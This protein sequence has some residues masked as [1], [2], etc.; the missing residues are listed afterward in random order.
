MN[1]FKNPNAFYDDFG[2]SPPEGYSESNGSIAV[3]GVGQVTLQSGDSP[4]PSAGDVLRMK[5]T[6]RGT[7]PVAVYPSQSSAPMPWDDYFELEAGQSLVYEHD[8]VGSYPIRLNF[9][10]RTGN[11]YAIDVLLEDPEGGNG[12]QQP[13]PVEGADTYSLKGFFSFGALTDNDERAV[14]PLGEL[15]VRSQTF[16]R[17]RELFTTGVAGS[18]STAIT[19][20]I[21]SSRSTADGPV[22]TPLTIGDMLASMGAWMWNEAGNGSFTSNPEIFRQALLAEYGTRIYDLNVG[23]MIQQGTIWLPESVT[24]YVFEEQPQTMQA[25]VADGRV[26]PS[27]GYLSKARVKMWLANAAFATQYDEYSFEF[28]APVDTLD[29]FFKTRGQVEELVAKRTDEE[30]FLKLQ[31]LADGDPYTLAK[32]IMFEFRDPTD[33]TYRLPTNWR[34]LIWGAAGDNIDAIKERLI[35]WILDNSE[36]TREEWAEIFPDI[37]TSTEF[38]LIPVYNPMAIPNKTLEPGMY[39]PVVE[40]ARA[41]PLA[42]KFSIGTAYTDAHVDRVNTVVPTSYKTLSLLAVGGPQNRDGVNKFFDQWT[43]YLAIATSNLDFDRMDPVTQGFIGKLHMLMKIAEEMT[44]FS[45]I[46]AGFTRLKRQ[47]TDGTVVMYVVA[48][49]ENV[50]YL[51]VS[52]YSFNRL[53]PPVTS[54]PLR[55]TVQGVEGVTT[56]ENGEPEQEYQEL[57]RA[58]GGTAPYTYS[59]PDAP[60]AYIEAQSI[61]PV[62]GIYRATFRRGGQIKLR[63]SATDATGAVAT[64]EFDLYVRELV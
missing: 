48:S 20:T 21:F 12:G 32:S 49:Y 6:N 62:T 52:K 16:S 15:S 42:R 4:M 24:F 26:D 7:G 63:V 47:K 34:F 17:D 38:I 18:N 45:D 27:P 5:V 64:T 35:E 8:L 1:F 59:L 11:V 31:Q 14:A 33:P 46:P 13:D 51:V 39:S 30:V 54:S 41:N 23:T 9:S 56:L 22:D 10:V 50:Q 60:H 55:V 43:D 61:D 36:H 29:D 28:L 44:E 58:L 3:T 53:S 57:F 2:N 37:F 40:V 19:A 25:M